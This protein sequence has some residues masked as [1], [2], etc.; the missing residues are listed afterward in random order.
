MAGLHVS[1]NKLENKDGQVLFLHGVNRSGQEADCVA[2]NNSTM[3]ITDQNFVNVVKSWNVNVVR[4]PLN[5]DCWLGI[6]ETP[7]NAPYM[8]AAYREQFT[9]VVNLLTSNN[10]AVIID[11][12]WT[13]P[14]TTVAT[15]QQPMPDADHASAFWSSVAST[16]A[17]NSSVIF[18][19]FNEPYPNFSWG[20]QS[21]AATWLCWLNGGSSC[22]SSNMGFTAVGMQSLLNTVRSAGAPNVVMVGGLQYANEM[23]QWLTYKPTDPAN[24]LAASW[25]MY[26]TSDYC[27]TESCWT[28]NVAPL[29]AQV[30]VITGESGFQPSNGICD[31]AAMNSFW[32]FEEANQQ[33]YLAWVFRA[34]G[35]GNVGCEGFSLIDDENGTPTVYGSNFFAHLVGLPSAYLSL[36]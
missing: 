10:L 35:D 6:N 19:L 3:L 25:H 13:A 24:N 1:G 12:H 33:G 23:G 34:W 30:P 29:M 31:I 26:G 9:S 22:A 5:E 8:G 16:F 32:S 20:V 27:S 4:L 11:L 7:S 21:P 36:P 2:A 17:S 14:G 15:G 28:A 18:D